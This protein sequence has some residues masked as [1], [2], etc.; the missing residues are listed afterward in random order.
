MKRILFLLL[1][2]GLS[3]AVASTSG[4]GLPW[5]GPLETI[6]QSISGPVAFVVSLLALIGAGAGLIWGGELSGFIK[7]LIYVVV[8]IA[9][10]VGANSFLSM[11]TTSGA[12]I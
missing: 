11:F 6:K 8:V 7:T 5:E 4:A 9:L 1:V 12:L 2:L 3:Y 10:I